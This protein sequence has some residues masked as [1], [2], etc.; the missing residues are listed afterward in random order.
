MEFD[1]DYFR[2]DVLDVEALRRTYEA[3]HREE[4]VSEADRP[5]RVYRDDDGG[6]DDGYRRL[7]S[8][9]QR[10]ERQCLFIV[11]LCSLALV[12]ILLLVKSGALTP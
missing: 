1:D 6:E 2:E 3:E 7:K 4:E 11:L 9:R 5:R 8:R 10:H 12:V